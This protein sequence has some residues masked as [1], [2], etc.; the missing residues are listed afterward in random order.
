M[1]KATYYNDGVKSIRNLITISEC[2]KMIIDSNRKVLEEATVNTGTSQ[3]VDKEIRNNY[4]LHFDDFGLAIKLYRRIYPYLPKSIDGWL[5]SGLN[6]RFRFYRYEKGQYFKWHQDDIYQREP[7][8]ESR[9][10]FLIYLNDD[11]EGGTTE[12]ETFAVA[13]ETGMAVLFPHTLNHQGSIIQTGTKYALRTD[14]MY[15]R[16]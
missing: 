14:I 11:Y 7:G 10:T 9:Y 13:P 15:E 6:E 12:F 1:N 4:R 8:V 3:E 5:T 16:S 2:R